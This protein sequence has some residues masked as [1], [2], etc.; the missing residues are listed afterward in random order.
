MVTTLLEMTP[1]QAVN[2]VFTYLLY[3]AGFGLLCL[4]L[5]HLCETRSRSGRAHEDRGHPFRAEDR[6]HPG[7]GQA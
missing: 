3:V 4:L 5:S 7:D 6:G 2:A 1:I